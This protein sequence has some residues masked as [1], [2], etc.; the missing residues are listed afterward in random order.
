MMKTKTL[1]LIGATG[2]TGNEVINAAL[3]QGYKLRVLARD[4][5]K[6]KVHKDIQIIK[7]DALNQASLENLIQGVDAVVSSLGPSGINQSLKKAKQSAKVGLCFNSTK[8]LIPLMEKAGIKRFIL[9]TGASLKTPQDNNSLFMGFMLNKVAPLIL[10]EMT[11]DRQAEYELLS[12][13]N[14]D[15]TY[16]RCGGILFEA[17]NN[18]IKTSATRFQG[19][20]IHPEKLAEFL[21]AQ[22]EENRYTRQA[23]FVAS[24]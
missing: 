12:Q 17:K 5:S 2:R 4:P 22:V 23:V 8:Q 3:A 15:W 16:A 11:H 21:L 20:K 7:G 10:G 13:S 18:K 1:A 19:G 6:V 14:L 9:T 24:H